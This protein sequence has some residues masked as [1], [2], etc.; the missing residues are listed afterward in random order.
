[1]VPPEDDNKIEVCGDSDFEKDSND[2]RNV[3]EKSLKQEKDIEN[4]FAHN[5]DILGT[6]D[7]FAAIR[8]SDV[9]LNKS[10]DLHENV[11]A[12]KTYKSLN[13]KGMI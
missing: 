3:E 13:A 12:E 6:Y 10:E 4:S 5:E 7:S 9:S 2:F 8:D 1:M 11:Q